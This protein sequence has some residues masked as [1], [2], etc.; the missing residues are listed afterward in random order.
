MS[1]ERALH[2]EN[3]SSPLLSGHLSAWLQSAPIVEL[4][5]RYKG[6]MKNREVDMGFNLFH[7]ISDVYHKENLHSDMMEALIST[8]GSHGH[9]D[10]FL[11][12]FLD[13]LR[14]RHGVAI[15]VA[16]YQGVQVIREDGRIDLLIYDETSHKAIIVE[17]KINGAPDM[18]RQLVRYLEK[19]T[20]DWGYTCEA[21]VYLCLNQKKHPDTPGWTEPERMKVSPLLRVVCAYDDG[22]EDDLY[23]GWLKP[24]LDASISNETAQ[25]HIDPSSKE[26]VA[27]VLR[28]YRQL[29]LKLGRTLMNK[30][31]MK[32]FYQMMLD[33]HQH[34][35][36]MAV[37]SM[38][39]DL[40]ASRCQRVLD[41]F[42]QD[43]SPFHKLSPYPHSSSPLAIFHGL[44]EG[45]IKL[46][47]DCAGQGF[48]K[49]DFWNNVNDD[50]QGD[51]PRRILND[52]GMVDSVSYDSESG[53]FTKV[54]RFPSEEGELYRFIRAFKEKLKDRIVASP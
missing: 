51:L 23:N 1:P 46:H 48:T 19:V 26:E 9:G 15:N 29:I 11:R 12:L 42:Q 40:P 30:P 16:D 2:E 13:F 39:N 32:D 17:N 28:Q 10:L 37:A 7:L 8:S 20:I 41:R 43:A 4:A 3:T 33:Q 5:R 14:K 38:V 18:D 36:A 27:H 31:I 22:S 6:F 54:F 25:P 49:L 45:N 50:P 53:W 52:I 21:I 34:D 47:V 24:C 35:S 44:G